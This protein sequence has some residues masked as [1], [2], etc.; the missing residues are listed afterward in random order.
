MEFLE[1][2]R[3]K[4]LYPIAS[5]QRNGGRVTL[6]SN[7][8]VSWIG[9]NALNSMF[10]IEMAVTRQRAG[11]KNYSTQA[12]ASERLS[13]DQASRAYTVDAAWQIRMENIIGTLEPGEK[14]DVVMLDRDPYLS[15]P[16]TP[17]TI[18]VYLTVSNGRVVYDR[19][20]L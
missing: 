10:N 15:D 16:Y 5:M 1:P 3:F 4:Q 18:K 7:Y 8:P 2:E 19:D 6:S 17:H 12:R 20:Q 11:D 14:A 9:K 13:V